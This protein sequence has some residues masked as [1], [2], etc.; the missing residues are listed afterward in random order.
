M[1]AASSLQFLSEITH[2][3][4]KLIMEMAESISYQVEEYLPIIRSAIQE[5]DYQSVLMTAHKLKTPIKVM[6]ADD[7]YEKLSILQV[8]PSD[9]YISE[10]VINGGYKLIAE[11]R[12]LIS[13]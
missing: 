5:G 1:K 12:N 13:C 10:L 2:G 3:D 9:P 4:K 6:G 8:N 11:I 7:L